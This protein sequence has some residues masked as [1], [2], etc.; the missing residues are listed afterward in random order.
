MRVRGGGF[1]GWVDITFLTVHDK[2]VHIF[3]MAI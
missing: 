2:F 1:G 3:E